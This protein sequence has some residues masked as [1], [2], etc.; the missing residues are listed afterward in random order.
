[1]PNVTIDYNSFAIST[2]AAVVILDFVYGRL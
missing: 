1:M 2:A